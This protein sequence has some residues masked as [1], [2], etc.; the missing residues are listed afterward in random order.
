MITLAI[1][2]ALVAVAGFA[3]SKRRAKN[4]SGGIGGTK[5]PVR[6]DVE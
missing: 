4:K 2:I 5:S 1:I 6:H 3:L